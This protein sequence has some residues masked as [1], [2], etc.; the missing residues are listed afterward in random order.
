MP[1]QHQNKSIQIPLKFYFSVKPKLAHRVVWLQYRSI[2]I[3]M[4]N[5]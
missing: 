5:G 2:Y 4:N 1:V 3:R